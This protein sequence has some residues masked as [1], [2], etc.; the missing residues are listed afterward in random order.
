[1]GAGNTVYYDNALGKITEK[2]FVLP[3]VEGDSPQL[4]S[5]HAGERSDRISRAWIL[6]LVI[7]ALLAMGGALL[8]LLPALTVMLLLMGGPLV[9][10]TVISG[11][12]ARHA[13]RGRRKGSVTI[14][15]TAPGKHLTREEV[16]CFATAETPPRPL[17]AVMG[18]ARRGY[19]TL[20]GLNE[21][22]IREICHA[23]EQLTL[24]RTPS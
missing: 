19:A 18:N 10:L 16:A 23:I 2:F 20:Q 1:M 11:V 21:Q 22:Q 12:T 7:P 17:K 4:K 3:G 6:L 14:Y 5:V 9:G 15:F 24:D 8:G 13:A